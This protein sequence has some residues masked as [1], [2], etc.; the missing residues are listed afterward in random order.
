MEGGDHERA[1]MGQ[2]P[3]LNTSYVCLTVLRLCSGRRESSVRN[4]I[5]L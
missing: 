5:V 3:R 1:G 4:W 2:A